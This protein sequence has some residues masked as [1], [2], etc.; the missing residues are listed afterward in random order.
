MAERRRYSRKTKV[1][2]VIA[3]EM[4]SVLAA[5]ESLK[6]PHMTLDYWFHHPEFVELRKKTRED[7]A[8]ESAALTHKVLAQINAKLPDYEAKD[9]NILFGILVDKSQLLS[10]EA[11]NRTESRDLTSGFDDHE[12]EALAEVLKRAIE[13][14]A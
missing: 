8:E 4:S 7:T 9:L 1:S 2:A 3:A 12:R 13:E 11:T 6:I 5:S 14:P 10:G